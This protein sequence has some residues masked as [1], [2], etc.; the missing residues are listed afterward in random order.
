MDK[1]LRKIAGKNKTGQMRAILLKTRIHI[2][3][4]FTFH[5]KKFWL[6][7]AAVQSER[8]Y[9]NYSSKRDIMFSGQISGLIPGTR[10]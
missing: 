3:Q 7:E 6:P 5:H 10:Q 4:G 8:D 9:A 2:F 1:Y